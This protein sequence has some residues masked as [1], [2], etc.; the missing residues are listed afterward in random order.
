MYFLDF[1]FFFCIKVS[2]QIALVINLVEDDRF[3]SLCVWL[4]HLYDSRIDGIATD[5]ILFLCA[6]NRSDV[7]VK[8][9][10]SVP[11]VDIFAPPFE[12]RQNY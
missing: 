9:K 8:K 12:N 1:F 4:L 7:P 2:I 3:I 11:C 6:F 5:Q 10:S